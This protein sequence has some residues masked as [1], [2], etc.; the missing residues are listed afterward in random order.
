MKKHLSWLLALALTLVF[1]SGLAQGLPT[2]TYTASSAGFGGDVSVSLTLENGV[3]T[4]AAIEGASETAGIGTRAIEALPAA[5]VAAN[6]ADVETVSG[7]TITSGAIRTA[8]QLALDEAFGAETKTL[9]FKAGA[10]KGSAFGNN[11]ELTVQVLTTTN[12]IESVQILSHKETVIVSDPAIERL[13]GKIVEYQTTSLDTVSGATVTSNA[14]L[15]AVNNALAQANADMTALAANAH[16]DEAGDP[17]EKSTQVVV[18]GAGGAGLAAAAAAVESGAE[19]ILIEKT[20]AIGGNTLQAGCGWCMVNPDVQGK[21]ETKA[22]QIET[23]K[24]Y[25]A[26]DPADYPDVAEELVAVQ[27]Q[28]REY[29]AGDTTYMFDTIE[30]FTF[31]TYLMGTRTGIDGTVIHGDADLI[32]TMTHNSTAVHEWVLK[33][34]VDEFRDYNTPIGGPWHRSREPQKNYTGKNGAPMLLAML[35]YL[36]EQNVDIMMETRATELIYE[37]GEIK[38]VICEQADGTPVTIHADNVI[39]CTGGYSANS[40]L[41]FKYNNYW[42]DL[43][44][45][46]LTTN[47]RTSTGDGIL[48]AEAIGAKLTGMEFVQLMPTSSPVTG[49]T[50]KSMIEPYDFIFVDPTG[51]RFVNEMSEGRDTLSEAALSIGSYFY[52]IMDQ[53]IIDDGNFAQSWYD[54]KVD[55]GIL[56]KADTLEELAGLINV[57]YD[58]LQATIDEYNEAVRTGVDP[59]GKT[60]MLNTCEVGPFY[61]CPR[62]PA[63]HYTMGGIAIN[64]TAQVIDVNGSVIPGLYAAGETTG[65]LHAGNRCGGNAI[66]EIFIFGK[67]AGEDAA[68]RSLNK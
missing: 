18:V 17:I 15:A 4:Q 7:A 68:A 66:A 26:L 34:G 5:I 14:I 64:P 49:D 67:I 41:V 40:E 56:V 54:S 33:F 27:G 59:Y 47:C 32:R 46:L 57:P 65:G 35:G 12:R 28:I 30:L 21:V 8:A 50:F 37:D 1:A 22:G 53:Q 39:L 38:G 20:A 58:A 52:V 10:Y 43:P 44:S 36:Q 42:K 45:D 29:L 16:Y 63:I 23:L 31:Q 6:S 9:S 2:G 19:V 11:G 60:E 3:I 62:R 24:S 55:E 61:A 48:M 13:P 25:L 51:H